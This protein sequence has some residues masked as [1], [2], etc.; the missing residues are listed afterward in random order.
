M[1]TRPRV[2]VCGITRREDAAL[3]VSLGADALGFIFWARSPR[4]IVPAAAR[5]IHAQ[6]PPFVTRVG[7][8]VNAS[9][10]EVAEATR[11]AG[12]DVVQLHGDEPVETYADVGARVMKVAALETMADVD[13]VLAWPLSVTPL[14][15]AVDRDR[16][17]GTGRV[18]DWA[19]AARVAVIRPIVLAGGLNA[20]NVCEAVSRVRPWAVDV[21]SGVEDAPGLKS[22][23]RLRAFFA[24]LAAAPLEDQ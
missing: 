17:G 5:A 24:S 2:K 20:D 15:D 3:A 19:L 1:T 10:D 11:V 18:A 6:L 22:P 23:T 4:A 8:F 14:V 13:R 7:V 9:P 12:L 16:R 21:S